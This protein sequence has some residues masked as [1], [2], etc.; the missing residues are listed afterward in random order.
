MTN[1]PVLKLGATSKPGTAF[2]QVLPNTELLSQLVDMGFPLPKASQAL[3][4]TQ[5]R[6][7]AA[8]LDWLEQHPYWI[9][10]TPAASVS[11]IDPSVEQKHADEEL[12]KARDI[13]EKAEQEKVASRI[14]DKE[15]EER[16]R[17]LE[18]QRQKEIEEAIKEKKEKQAELERVRKQLEEDKRARTQKFSMAT[19][20]SPSQTQLSTSSQ[21][22]SR[23]VNSVSSTSS[24]ILQIRLPNG[25]ALKAEFKPTDTI[26]S[27]Y[28][29][30]ANY[31]EP[32]TN[33]LLIIPFPRKEFTEAMV[34]L[35][36]KD[37][38]LVPR[39]TLNVLTTAQRG[40]IKVVEPQLRHEQI[41]IDQMSYEQ[42][43][44]L[45][46]KVGQVNTGVPKERLQQFEVTV[47]EPSTF[48]KTETTK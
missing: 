26:G 32:G 19:T 39:G 27:V 37:A 2:S 3:I 36:L 23:A 11:Q 1:T 41:N 20:S 13:I 40:V 33:F 30:V 14:S 44:D 9:A 8:A 17:H 34:N 5:N 43:L 16:R 46:A 42:L 24:C 45:E 31:L 10:P 7:L 22:S 47:F 25:T 4:E 15:S 29:Y 6:H 18:K 12:K 35:T 28:K 38:D 48:P 21:Q